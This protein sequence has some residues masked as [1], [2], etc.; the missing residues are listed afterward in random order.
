VLPPGGLD[1]ESRL[2]ADARRASKNLVIL[3]RTP[4]PLLDEATAVGFLDGRFGVSGT[5][6]L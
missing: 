5:P 4:L 6:P 3:K 1:L 2:H